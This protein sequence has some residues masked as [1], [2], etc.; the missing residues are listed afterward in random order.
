MQREEG[1]GQREES[2]EWKAERR[3]QREEAR[4]RK[5]EKGRWREEG[6]EYSKADQLSRADPPLLKEVASWTIPLRDTVQCKLGQTCGRNTG[7]L[8]VL[9][10]H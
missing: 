1:R 5:A 8:A 6:N 7:Q 3:R 10:P 9:A 4:K 2:R